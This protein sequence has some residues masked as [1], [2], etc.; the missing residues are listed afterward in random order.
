MVLLGRR[1]L[2]MLC[3]TI[4][5]SAPVSAASAQ[6]AARAI[7]GHAAASKVAVADGEEIIV[8]GPSY[9]ALDRYIEELTAAPNGDQL[10]RWNEPVCPRAVG[11]AESQNTFLAGRI[12]SVAREMDIPVARGR[13]RTNILVV[14]T[15]E[16]DAFARLLIKRHPKLFGAYGGDMAP[17]AAVNGL[18]APRPVRWL[19]ASDWG[20][21]DG[22]PIV[23]G[24]KNFIYSAS[25]L[26]ET[27]R[28]NATLSLVVVDSTRV[29]G[30][31]WGSLANYIAMVSLALPAPDAAPASGPT[32]LGLFRDRDSNRR[33]ASALS[34]WDRDYLRNLYATKASSKASVQRAQILTNMNRHP[35][36]GDGRGDQSNELNY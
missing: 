8:N 27:T 13:C 34:R 3:A 22:A 31:K 12:A 1:L 9:D 14:V 24:N 15:Q 21:A 18:L 29:E 36:T 5:S 35:E 33:G 19:N 6:D 32:I 2:Y 20:N 26:E 28:Q 7:S 30:V 25:R 17:A 4:T 10:A 16:A 11:I 23:D